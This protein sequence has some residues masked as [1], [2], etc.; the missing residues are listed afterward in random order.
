[1]NDLETKRA[2]IK[3]PNLATTINDGWDGWSRTENRGL[4]VLIVG[5]Q[6]ELIIFN[7][8]HTRTFREGV[9]LASGQNSLGPVNTSHS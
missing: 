8:L 5:S 1:M 7:H 4:V 3:C 6:R 9:L 2:D